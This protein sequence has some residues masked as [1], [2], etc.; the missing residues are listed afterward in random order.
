VPVVP[1]MFVQFVDGTMQFYH[2]DKGPFDHVRIN[3]VLSAID[4]V[5]MIPC[6]HGIQIV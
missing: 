4:A 5:D 3:T 2:R 1:M 6:P